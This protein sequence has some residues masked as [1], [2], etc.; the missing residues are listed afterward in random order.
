MRFKR[1]FI[2][3]IAVS[4]VALVSPTVTPI[5][6]VPSAAYADTNVSVSIGTFYDELAPHGSWVNYQDSYVFV[7]A[8]VAADWRPYT[9]GHWVHTKRYGWLWVSDEP[10]GW[11]TYHYGRWGYA[12][13]IGWYWV[14]GKRWAPAWV[15]WRRS[16][17]YVVWAPLPPGRDDDVDVVVEVNDIPDIYWVA[18]PA[19][20][21]LDV[22]LSV[23]IVDDDAERVRFV[24]AAEPV[25]SV[26]IEN[27]IVVNNVI[28]VD[29]VE[30][31]TEK[32]VETVEVKET[33]DPKQVGKGT[34][35][36]VAVFSGEV[37][38]EKDAKPAEVKDVEEVK[39]QKA[40]TGGTPQD[41]QPGQDT[42]QGQGTTT[43]EQDTTQG[44]EQPTKKK[45]Q[46]AKGTEE[47]AQQQEAQPE[48]GQEQPVKKKQQKAKG[49]EQP[50]QQQ[51]A[52]PE[53]GQ[54]QPV[55]KKQRKAK[56]IEQPAQQQEAQ[57]QETIQ[58]KKQ[59]AKA[60]GQPPQSEQGQEQPMQKQ[61]PQEPTQG[62]QPSEPQQKKPKGG[63]DPATGEGC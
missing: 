22:D 7:P 30:K 54:E 12:E 51:E 41:Q 56:G 38:E 31:T 44:Q 25:G 3:S 9:V 52:Q 55:K 33:D 35:G 46:K 59:K 63:C 16:N 18:V 57:P 58:K 6:D 37:K 15:S 61:A 28:D 39:K 29:Y 4:A 49:T 5:I 32:K 11:A 1:L 43:Q 19:Q 53:E 34:E 8:N 48:E 45:R 60:S 50:A 27:N 47:P 36:E 24:E 2:Y 26:T 20:S 40:E 62:E 21:F 10:F 17:D 13:D 23:V 42:T 14:P